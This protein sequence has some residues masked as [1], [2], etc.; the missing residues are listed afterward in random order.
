MKDETKDERQ[1]IKERERKRIWG[2]RKKRDFHH[3][4]TSNFTD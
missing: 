1:I 3:F 2:K 4:L